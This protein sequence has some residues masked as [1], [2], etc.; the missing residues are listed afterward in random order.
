MLRPLVLLFALSL[1][2]AAQ[3]VRMADLDRDAARAI[4]PVI[5]AAETAFARL[6]LVALTSNIRGICGGDAAASDL[7]R[8]CTGRNTIYVSWD[9]D[10]RLAGAP[11][12]YLMAHML[13]HGVQ[14]RHGLAAATAEGAKA[15]Q[16]EM[17]AD[18]LAGVIMARA[19]LAPG[20]GPADWFAAHPLTRAHWGAA[21]LA[22]MPAAQ[23]AVSLRDQWYRRGRAGGDVAA[24]ATEDW[25][26]PPLLDAVRD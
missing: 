7:M 6:P 20:E 4:A 24:C 21:P 10:D 26:A 18:C 23:V 2:A 1:P 16:L 5:A 8:Y 12:A 14:V 9:V 13:S 11:L 22:A 3:T 17:Q 15:A 19:D 25:P